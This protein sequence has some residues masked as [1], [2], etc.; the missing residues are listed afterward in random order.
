[1][2]CE[3]MSWGYSLVSAANL[4]LMLAHDNC[5]YF[6]Q[7]VPCEP[8]EYGMQDVIRA[9]TRRLCLCTRRAGP[10]PRRGLGGDGGSHHP[11]DCRRVR[12]Y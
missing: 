12:C 10:R 4:H 3:I 1:M 5:S 11:F 8:Y 6:E 9:Q 7:S 2:K